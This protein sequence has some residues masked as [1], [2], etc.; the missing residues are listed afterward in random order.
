MG[1][2]RKVRR[3]KEQRKKDSGAPLHVKFLTPLGDSKMYKCV[4]LKKNLEE[5]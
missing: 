5:W 2:H 4:M 1:V 3:V